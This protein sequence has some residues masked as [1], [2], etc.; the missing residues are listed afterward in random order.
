MLSVITATYN[1]AKLLPNLYKSILK[2]KKKKSD[3]EWVIVDDGSM[4]DTKR[5][6]EKWQEEKKINITYIYQ[7][8]QGKMQALNHG[9]PLCQGEYILEVDSDDYLLDDV[10][11]K[12]DSYKELLQK[13]KGVY[14]LGFLR[15]VDNGVSIPFSQSGMVRSMY[16][17]YLK[18][19]YQGEIALVFKQSARKKFIHH[20][21]EGEKFIT[22]SRMYHE[23]DK[24]YQGIVC[25]NEYLVGGIYE[26]D[27]YTKNIKQMFT[28]CPK[29][30]YH[31]FLELLNF[32][33][34]KI[35]LGKYWYAIKQYLL[36]THL[37]GISKCE[38]KKG[39]DRW[40]DQWLVG[41]CYHLA[42]K[43]VKKEYSQ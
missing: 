41:F 30:Y 15:K 12:L 10:L 38:C 21:E 16:E 14:A 19:G 6:V 11:E 9:I 20:L 32:P 35:T 18:D 25:I 42:R 7:E 4:D 37:L 36:F 3:I 2:N 39:L 33:N 26:L 17:L 13:N 40:Y 5:L 1:R 31:Y 8:N 28:K 22:E 24:K 34:R 27:G 29:G 43:K 23:M